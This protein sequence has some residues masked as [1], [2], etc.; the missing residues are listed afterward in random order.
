MLPLF[1][2]LLPHI[3][4]VLDFYTDVGVRALEAM[5]AMNKRNLELYRQLPQW[6]SSMLRMEP[7]HPY[8]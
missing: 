3:D 5:W 6:P 4:V 8:L 7:S 2:P 1:P